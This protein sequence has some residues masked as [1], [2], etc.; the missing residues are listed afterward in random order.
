MEAQGSCSYIGMKKETHTILNPL[1]TI[2]F[3]ILL[4]FGCES[5]TR[6]PI[7]SARVAQK[8]QVPLK[9]VPKPAPPE[10]RDVIWVN[11]DSIAMQE[12]TKR[13]DLLVQFRN[14]QNLPLSKHQKLAQK[15]RIEDL[16]IGQKLLNQHAEKQNIFVSDQLVIDTLGTLIENNFLSRDAFLDHLR[17]KSMTRDDYI[18]QL[19]SDMISKK[20]FKNIKIEKQEVLD[21]FFQDFQEDAIVTKA[22]VRLF[23]TSNK[24]SHPP[25]TYR[26]FR[27]L[28]IDLKATHDLG[29]VSVKDAGIPKL[30]FSA[31]AKDVITVASDDGTFYYWI[32]KKRKVLNPNFLMVKHRL[33][34]SLMRE[35][36]EAARTNLIKNLRKS[37][38]IRYG[39]PQPGLTKTEEARKKVNDKAGR[40]TAEE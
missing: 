5:D 35:K 1:Q 21:R 17:F 13:L 14:S 20:I 33:R 11:G 10:K 26:K 23:Q 3:A 40:T 2:A 36:R 8:S 7:P 38:I 19:K 30:I 18:D 25:M 31:N 24:R 34:L 37:A 15:K 39:I 16:L 12:V 6:Q 29:W 9:V 32:M 22:K 4:V 28:S 27:K